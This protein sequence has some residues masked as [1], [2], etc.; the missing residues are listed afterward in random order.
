[1]INIYSGRKHSQGVRP[2]TVLE[3][4]TLFFRYFQDD[5][6]GLYMTR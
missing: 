3:H 1:M 2:L 5:P 4:H 6:A